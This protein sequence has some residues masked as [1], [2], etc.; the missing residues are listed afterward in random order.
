MFPEILSK[1][2]VELDKHKIPYM[3]MGGQAVLLYGEPRLT[4][5]VNITLGVDVDEVERVLDCIEKLDLKILVESHS[6]FVKSTMVLPVEDR[7][8]GMRIDFIFSYS[9]YERQ[10]IERSKQV[11]FSGSILHFITLEDL[12]IEKIFSGRPRDLEDVK[13]I[14]LKNK[15]FDKDYVLRWLKDF[16]AGLNIDFVRSFKNIVADIK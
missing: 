14:M 1:V 6:Q 5:D 2:A 9:P 4:R 12:I 3:I 11:N 16:S 7:A 8:T 13:N 10:A 15:T